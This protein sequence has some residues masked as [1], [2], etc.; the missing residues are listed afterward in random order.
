MDRW[1]PH[2]FAL[3]AR[4]EGHS[5]AEVAKYSAHYE[6]AAR[7]GIAPVL[8]LRHL[9]ESS[10]V[11]YRHLRSRCERRPHTLLDGKKVKP[12]YTF[13]IKKRSGGKRII[14][15]P[16]A[17][18]YRV[19]SWMNHNILKRIPTHHRSYAYRTGKSIVDCAA[20]HL[21]CRWLVKLDLSQFF[22][23]ITERQV[24]TVFKKLNYPSLVSFEMARLCTRTDT[25][26]NRRKVGA[27]WESNRRDFGI[28]EYNHGCIGYLPQGA[29]T[30]PRLSN[31]VSR[32]MDQVLTDYADHCGWEYS[33]YSDDMYLS[34]IQP[35]TTKDA[36]IDVVRRVRRIAEDHG[37]ILNGTKTRIAGPG[38]RKLVLGILVDRNRPRL[39]REFRRR[40]EW[41]VRQCAKD[42]AAHAAKKGFDSLSGLRNHVEGLLA[43]ARSV[44]PEYASQLSN[45]P[46]PWPV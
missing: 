26:S 36:A 30:S 38:H 27:K 42:P 9:A 31:L 23:S 4:R 15:I 5:E 33:R 6:N 29:P 2:S 7:L 39:S 16:A 14:S 34:S 41:H 10:G 13:A 11:E 44:D 43:F 1:A 35:E 32:K 40:V 37:F 21:S 28:P 20:V 19:Q 46:I 17:D 22:E 18:V 8:T 24:Y 25:F 12:Y 45:P 3:E